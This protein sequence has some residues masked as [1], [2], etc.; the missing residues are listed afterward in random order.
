VHD[1]DKPDPKTQLIRGCYLEALV[2]KPVPAATAGLVDL[3]SD[4]LDLEVRHQAARAIAFGGMTPQ[5]QSQLFDKL[6][7]PAIRDDAALALLIGGDP[8]TV[9]RMMATY[10]DADVGAME[11]LKVIYD[12]TFGYWS[13]K[14]YENGDVARWI[15]NAQQ[16]SRVKVRDSL[17]D[18]PKLI[19]ARAIQGIDYDNGPHSVT[20]VQ[21]R[22]RLMRDARSQ[23]E[24]KRRQ[25]I[26]ILK[27]MG[28][29][30]VLMALKGE[31]G[32]AQELAREAFFELMN[33]KVTTE[34][35]P[36]AKDPKGGSGGGSNVVPK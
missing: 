1:F 14:N 5:I 34:A 12:Q 9:R 19:L 10:N 3:I 15:E 30:G 36:A 22:I 26:I 28:E 23:D 7:D 8:D 11:N 20:R 35:L 21:M 29:K 2:R 24:K 13:D 31:Q 17:Q 27:F 6:K 4:K 32:P 33:P 25:A 16:A 18:W